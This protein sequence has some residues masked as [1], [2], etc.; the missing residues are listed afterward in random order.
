[1]SM[2]QRMSIIEGHR[3]GIMPQFMDL[4]KAKSNRQIDVE[5][6]SANELNH[7]GLT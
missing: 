1:M 6:E 5:E 3:H 7:D 2:M 4:F